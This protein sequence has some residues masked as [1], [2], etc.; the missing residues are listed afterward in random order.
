MSI[1]LNKQW[2]DAVTA[3]RIP[4]QPIV[5]R[6]GKRLYIKR[7]AHVAATQ[8]LKTTHDALLEWFKN[9]NFDS[10]KEISAWNKN[11]PFKV[12]LHNS[13]KA[14]DDIYALET[15]RDLILTNAFQKIKAA[16]ENYTPQFDWD[17]VNE[18]T[19]LRPLNGTQRM[20]SHRITIKED[21]QTD[22]GKEGTCASH[23]G[24]KTILQNFYLFVHPLPISTEE[25]S[26]YKTCFNTLKT[27]VSHDL[28]EIDALKCSAN[29]YSRII[30]FLY[31]FNL[32]K[33]S[34]ERGVNSLETLMSYVLEMP[35]RP[36]HVDILKNSQARETFLSLR[37]HMLPK[38]KH[39]KWI[40][41]YVVLRDLKH[42]DFIHMITPLLDLNFYIDATAIADTEEHGVHAIT[43]V[44]STEKHITIINSWGDYVDI[45][46]NIHGFKLSGTPYQC[47]T[48]ELLLPINTSM[49]QPVLSRVIYTKSGFGQLTTY[50]GQ[51]CN[52][53]RN[54]HRGGSRTKKN[55]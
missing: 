39:L 29:G 47:T 35:I 26:Q 24:A 6:K 46:D 17:D 15:A 2:K 5:E 31:L 52:E 8:S 20:G 1:N 3:L 54:S 49:R 21:F 53:I 42:S 32:I 9:F 4:F 50:I 12:I 45:I 16:V 25:I 44:A 51:Y 43:I 55:H 14:L 33:N 40:N 41:F 22:Q 7:D 30:L 11:A 27:D 36:R 19:K 18:P 23:A 38:L 37:R 10:R 48:V 13:E 28:N 34:R